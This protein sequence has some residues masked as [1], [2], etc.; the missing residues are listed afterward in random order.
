MQ[1][2]VRSTASGSKRS[3]FWLLTMVVLFGCMASRT[4]L[5]AQKS[6]PTEKDVLQIVERCFLCHGEARQM[7]S[8]DLRTRAGMLEGGNSGPAIVPGHADDS[9]LIKRVSGLVKPQMPMSP[10]PA[11]KAEEIAVLKDWIDQGA[12]GNGD[13]NPVSKAAPVDPLPSGVNTPVVFN[14]YK[15]RVIRDRDRQWWSF[16]PPVRN[17]APAVSDARW[18]RNPIDAFVKKTMEAKGLEPAP[19]ADK[20]TLIRRVYL[21]LIGLLPPPE[22]VEAFVKDDSPDAYQKLVDRLLDSPNYGE[23]WGRFWLDVVRYAD[24]SGFEYDRDISD[25]WRYRDYVVKAF[26]Q[27]KPF[28]QFV[29]EQLAGDEVDQPSDDSLTATSYYRIGPRVRF[30][31]KQNP[32]N[33]YDYMDDVIRTTFQGFM[34]LSVNCARCHDHKFDPITRMDYY[35]SMAMFWGYVDYDQPLA[36][37]EKVEEYER[38]KR[39]VDRQAAPLRARIAQIEKPYKDKEQQAKRE[40]ALKKF[41]EDIRIAIQTPPEK[42][43][44]GQK[45]LVSQLVLNF[46][47]PDAADNAIVPADDPNHTRRKGLIKV[48]KEDDAERQ[49]L[50]TKIQEIEKRMPPPL[51]MAN[52]VRDGDYWLT[53]DELGDEILAG[54]GRYNYDKKCCFVPN[55]GEKYE[56]PDLHFAANGGDFDADLKNPTVQPGFLTVLVNGAAPP[57]S[58]RPNRPDYPTSGRRRA[59]ADWIA[60]PDNPLTSRV[61]VNRIW[62]WHFGTAIVPTPGNFGKM[63][64]PPTNPELLDWLATEFI[65]QGWSIKQMQRLIMNSETY[66]MA[67]SFYREEDA[68]NDPNDVYLWK[69]PIHRVEGELVRD[70]TLSASGQL[71]PQF[72]G[73][74]FFPS[75]PASVRQTNGRGIWELTKEDPSTWRRSIYAYVQRGLR[76]PMFEVFDQPDLNITCERRNV[77]TVPTQAL[78]L[79]NNPLMLIQSKYLAERVIREAKNDPTE[80]IKRMYL[81][82][83][84]REPTQVELNLNL[85]FLAKQRESAL[86]HGA[87][88]DA[89]ELAALADLAQVMLDSDEFIYIG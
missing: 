70:M 50:L 11:L 33:R 42:R 10:V 84:S 78:T 57:T 73:K 82:T 76:Y 25:A 89:A 30:R 79:L 38:I 59:L 13:D 24:S 2:W 46:D 65:R 16:R 26:N 52:A 5:V 31:E 22:V 9:L 86:A 34:G 36:P 21:D 20:R 62:G 45:L 53:P 18:S 1:H 23:R 32:S 7:A 28:N 43:T 15:E 4:Q 85:T 63:G 27:D 29:V 49:E 83:L 19:Q 72:G 3:L 35:R 8:L 41:P 67:S 68:R 81:I 47:D 69:F 80:R 88:A 6:Q 48:S 61:I 60:S 71:N 54:N 17:P 40:E 74:P 39:E 66:K 75:I 56:V 58:H 77:S 64:L 44:A 87:S 12:K 55:A 14:G 37:K 51:P